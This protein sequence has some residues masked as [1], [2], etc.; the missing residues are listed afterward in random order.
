VVRF[1]RSVICATGLFTL[2]LSALGNEV[3][4]ARVVDLIKGDTLLVQGHRLRQ[5]VRLADVDAPELCQAFGIRAKEISIGLIKDTTVKIEV[6]AKDAAGRMI[7]RVTTA[8]NESLSDALAER[9]AVW[10]LRQNTKDDRL[11]KAEDDAR[12]YHVG[13]WNDLNPRPPWEWRATGSCKD[14]ARAHTA[15]NQPA[16]GFPAKIPVASNK[17]AAGSE[18]LSTYEA[19]NLLGPMVERSEAEVRAAAALGG[20]SS[21][22]S[23]GGHGPIQT[24]PRGGRYYINSNGN[25]TYVGRGR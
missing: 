19:A 23:Y 21:D 13:L 17:A 7:G 12:K 22:F 8:S 5:Y 2:V 10:V 9:G 24:G 14:V 6:V 16:S 4:D 25:K 18:R 20:Y 1:F 15:L 11:L 3:M